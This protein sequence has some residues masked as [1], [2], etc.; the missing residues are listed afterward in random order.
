M[1]PETPVI[2][3]RGTSVPLS[4]LCT[5]VTIDRTNWP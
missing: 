4:D 2:S 3:I 5:T 1:T